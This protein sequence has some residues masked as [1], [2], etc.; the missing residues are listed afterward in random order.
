MKRWFP[1]VWWLCWVTVPRGGAAGRG[2]PTPQPDVPFPQPVSH[3]Y[4]SDPALTEANYRRLVVDGEDRVFVLTDRGVCRLFNDRLVLD[5]LYRPLQGRVA[6]DIGLAQGQVFY[7]FEREFLCNG[8]S[9]RL[10]AGLPEGDFRHFAVGPDFSALLVGPTNAVLFREPQFL[11][12]LT[13]ASLG[14]ERVY[15]GLDGFYTLSPDSIR[16]VRGNQLQIFHQG[17]G[18]TAL[19]FRTNQVLVGTRNGYY[20]LDPRT[21]RRTLPLQDRLPWNEITA[22]AP[23][24]NGL[25]VGTSRGVFL[26]AANGMIRYFASRR[27]LK[28]DAVVDLQ[29]DRAGNLWVLTR[30]GL[31]QIA[32]P[33]MTLY[34][35]ARHYERLIRE[36][37]IR[38][39]LC[40]E[41]RL[42]QP[43][44]VAS[45]ELI[46]TD[47]DGSWTSYY[48]ASQVFH[49]AVT[50]EPDVLAHVWEAFSALEHLQAINGLD[51]F[52]ARTYE[53]KG[54]KVS[55][56]DR[57]RPAPDPRWEWKGHTSSDEIT[58][59]TFA[60]ALMFE[61][62]ARNTVERARV[63]AAYRRLVDHILKHGYQLV[64]V[65]GRPTLWGRWDPDY[66]NG[67]PHSIVDR[68]LNS[69]EIIA[70]L[71]LAAR[72][73]G[74]EVYQQHGL[75]LLNQQ[76]YLQNI[77]SPMDEIRLTPG[78]IYQG[79]DMGDVWNHSDDLL[80]FVNYW[81]L[82]RFAFNNQVR[83]LYAGAVKEHW[84]IE[85][86][87]RNPLWSFILAM[88]GERDCDL[89]GALWTLRSWPLDLITWDIRNSHR[90]DIQRLAPNFRRQE[91]S[92]LLPPSERPM[93]RW[94][95]NPF[96]LDGGNG[97]RTELAGNEFLLPYWMGRFLR[98][99]TAPGTPIERPATRPVPPSRPARP[100]TTS[101][102]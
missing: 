49:Y 77:L 21:G 86:I 60:Y 79:H 96:Q 47:N 17:S 81:T 5:G 64:D 36:R 83:S 94:N 89:L 102:P 87:E 25:W 3:Q 78:H 33:R 20:G 31:S 28:D 42:R 45:G 55:D 101:N 92:S 30:T 93:M 10:V 53:R 74:E 13:V 24:T 9:G 50:R 73:T 2:V 19:A 57:W 84:R 8:F 32:F 66:V 62:V 29:P 90:L 6:H 18:L 39:G 37:H 1:L 40:A 98:L 35:K 52:P 97:G 71:Q 51:G 67:Y 4:P 46:D 85:R 76:G 58:A 22:L 91:T 100:A 63:S 54:F 11:P 23:A 65:D 16:R 99:I 41:L 72:M 88:T 43:G 59:Q 14:I 44:E 34:E 7:L 75:T 27:W 95:G 61:L 82:Y 15:T 56:P 12:L 26:H 38:Y 68:R 80:A 69:A 48:L 70:F